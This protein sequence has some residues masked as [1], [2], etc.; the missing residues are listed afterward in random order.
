M[1]RRGALSR[2]D[3]GIWAQY[4][5][6]VR[7]LKGK[8]AP[9]LPVIVPVADAPQVA[10]AAVPAAPP[11]RPR[12]THEIAVG[13]APGGLDRATWQRFSSARMKV[14]R[15]LDLHGRTVEA[16]FW[17]LLHFIASARATGVRHIEIVTGMGAGERGGAIRAEM[18]HWLNL[19]QIKPHILTICHPHAR[20]LGAV[21]ILLR[22]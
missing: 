4:A 15:R 3:E 8:T 6:L 12:V 18:P 2:E 9:A 21:R 16:A 10:A 5:A 22:R 11:R 13:V 20:N 7:P 1:A 19:P 17:A 14:E